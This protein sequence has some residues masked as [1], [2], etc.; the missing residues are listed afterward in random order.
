MLVESADTLLMIDCGLPCREVE[1]R[2]AALGRSAE[3]VS[4]LLITHEHSDHLRGV[5]P[6]VR[7]YGTPVLTTYGTGHALAA[8]AGGGELDIEPISTH[9]PLT[10]G[11]ISVEPFPVPHDA[12]EP[13][14]FA[15]AAGGRRL[16]LLT[17]AGHVTV[18]IRERLAACDALAVE[19][20]HDVGS[21]MRGTYPPSVKARVGSAYGHLS[22]HEAA[23]L[24]E[25]IRHGGL[26]WVVA[27]HMSER[28]NSPE[29]VRSALEPA[30]DGTDAR[31]AIA[32]QGAPSEWIEVE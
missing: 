8:T 31:I 15:F 7:R 24:V 5:G 18:H 23:A 2:L 9:R 17:D 20:N 1:Q 21:L 25:D 3:D 13:C 11:S 30:V 10:L 28:N 22:N 19:F 12:R 27:M 29:H 6:F 16:G 26:Q 4:A 14:Q 32:E